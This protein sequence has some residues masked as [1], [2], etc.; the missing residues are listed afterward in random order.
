MNELVFKMSKISWIKY[1]YLKNL[2]LTLKP[3]AQC[4]LFVV[5]ATIT[6][7]TMTFAFFI[8]PISNSYMILF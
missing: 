6:D 4:E 1:L 3:A 7:K 2:D 8:V 5:I